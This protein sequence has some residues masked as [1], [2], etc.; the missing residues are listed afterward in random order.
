[1][2]TRSKF[3]LCPISIYPFGVSLCAKSTPLG[4]RR[5][6]QLPYHLLLLLMILQGLTTAHLVER[7]LIKV[8]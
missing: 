8:L 5:T 6:K 7:L 4:H 1:M 2:I 3:A